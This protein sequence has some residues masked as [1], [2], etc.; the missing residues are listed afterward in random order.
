MKF[1]ATSHLN[2]R[3]EKLLIFSKNNSTDQRQ[4]FLQILRSSTQIWGRGRVHALRSSQSC[5]HQGGGVSLFHLPVVTEYREVVTNS[6]ITP[7]CQLHVAPREAGRV[8]SHLSVAPQR[9]S[10]MRGVSCHRPYPRL[11][12]ICLGILIH[13]LSWHECSN[14]FAWLCKKLWYNVY[15]TRLC[16]FFF[17]SVQKEDKIVSWRLQLFE[18]S[19]FDNSQTIKSPLF[20][21]LPGPPIEQ[22]TRA[23]K[24]L[25]HVVLPASCR[26]VLWSYI[27]AWPGWH[28]WVSSFNQYLLLFYSC[29]WTCRFTWQHTEIGKV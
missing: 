11:L 14:R 22:S 20:F 10:W 9:A 23:R 7:P 27:S 4:K 26:N 13:F 3:H 1:L 19:A 16:D 25:C 8:S 24:F 12:C 17:L 21:P 5:C 18:R 29:I 6:R 15:S 28:E 2:F